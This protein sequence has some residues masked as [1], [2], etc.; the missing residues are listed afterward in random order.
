MARC[1]DPWATLVIYSGGRRALCT[2]TDV[3]DSVAAGLAH[4]PVRLAE[5]DLQ[6]HRHVVPV[7]A[8]AQC[9]SRTAVVTRARGA[10]LARRGEKSTG[11]FNGFTRCSPHQHAD[12]ALAA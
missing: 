9:D 11:G 8:V 1:P 4:S 6:A 7:A 2:R 3:G 5:V 10:E 12:F